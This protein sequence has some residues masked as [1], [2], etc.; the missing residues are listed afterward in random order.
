MEVIE[1]Q[2]LLQVEPLLQVV[3]KLSI[4]LQQA[5]HSLWLQ[6]EVL[7]QMHLSFYSTLINSMENQYC[8]PQAL[9]MKPPRIT[10]FE[11]SCKKHDE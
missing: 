8:G 2:L 7:Y 11:A 10:F 6:V 5:V 3:D 9:F 1:Y 4:H